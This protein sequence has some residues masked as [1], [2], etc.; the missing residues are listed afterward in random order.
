MGMFI[1][2]PHINLGNGY[3]LAPIFIVFLSR[4][5][6]LKDMNSSFKSIPLE[7]NS[8]KML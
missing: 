4:W 2:K 1:V 7:K 3:G 6:V 5:S 8:R